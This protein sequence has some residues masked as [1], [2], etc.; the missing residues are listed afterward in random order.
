MFVFFKATGRVGKFIYQ[1][2]R[3]LTEMDKYR[4]IRNQFYSISKSVC[5]EWKISR[6]ATSVGLLKLE[7]AGY[8]QS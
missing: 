7:E 4:G 6:Q 2:L 5:K 1:R 3:W 8:T